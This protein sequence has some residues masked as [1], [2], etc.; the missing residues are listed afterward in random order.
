MAYMITLLMRMFGYESDPEL[1]EKINNSYESLRV[2]GRGTIKVD[3][4]EV[5]ASIKE[6]GL[7]TAAKMVVSRN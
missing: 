1:A 3:V 6:Q 2:V 7:Y 4:L 5:T